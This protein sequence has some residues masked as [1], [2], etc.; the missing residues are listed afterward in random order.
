MAMS[1]RYEQLKTVV[2]SMW[3]AVGYVEGTCGEL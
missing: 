2:F 3:S 1:T